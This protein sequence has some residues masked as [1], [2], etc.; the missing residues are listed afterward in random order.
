MIDN[1][2]SID[3]HRIIGIIS[4]APLGFIWITIAMVES[5]VLFD[6]VNARFFG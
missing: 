2:D 3:E 4:E 6:L 1:D 5:E